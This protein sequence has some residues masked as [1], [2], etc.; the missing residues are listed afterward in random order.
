MAEDEMSG[1]QL[2]EIAAATCGFTGDE[3]GNLMG[4]VANGSVNGRFDFGTAWTVIE[5]KVKHHRDG[6]AKLREHELNYFECGVP[7]QEVT[8]V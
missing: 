2:E 3:I 6:R 5:E 8:F 1:D 7:Q 4:I